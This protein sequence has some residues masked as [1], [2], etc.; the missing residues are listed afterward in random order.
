M[1]ERALAWS[2][3]HISGYFR[4][5]AGPAPAATGSVGGG[6][7]IA[8][9]V[10]VEAVPADEPSVRVLVRAPDGRVTVADGSP[11]VEHLM[12]RLGAPAALTTR[13]TLPI[14]AGFGLS[15]AALLAAG[16]ALSALH[17]LDL[18]RSEVAVV[19]HEAEVR[20]RTGLGDVA[21]AQGG[22][23]VV[24]RGPGIGAEVLRFFSDEP[25]CAVSFG[26]I[27]TPGVLDSDDAMA[28]VRA[29]FPAEEPRDLAG[30]VRASRAFAEASGLAT[31]RV[32][33]ALAACDA[34]GVPASMTMLGDG[35]FATGPG[36]AETL[37]RFGPVRRL[38]VAAG[39]FRLLEAGA[40]P[41][42]GGA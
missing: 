34:A 37:A 15:A 9:G 7:V 27:P 30:L 28:R 14:G 4:R 33:D 6:I 29:A 8:E 11:P 26:P 2:P 38:H 42:G 22:G 16:A 13:C 18:A 41:G 12:D 32:R 5:C 3:G 20:F 35:V 39:G 24:R 21:A 17:G 36:A 25:V 40:P 1:V 10:T 31:D 19:A 23:V